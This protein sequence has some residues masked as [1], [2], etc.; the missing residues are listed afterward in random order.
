[1]RKQIVGAPTDPAKYDEPWINL[2]CIACVRLTSEDPAFPI[3]AAL[4][5]DGSGRGWKAAGAG[6]QS[7]WLEFD[8]PRHIER[9]HICFEA[10]ETRT[11]EFV[12]SC[13]LEGGVERELLRQ[14]FNFS[15]TT[16][17]EVEN[18]QVNLSAVTE[19]KVTITPDISGGDARASMR[20]LAVQ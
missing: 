13:T 11:Q 8:L 18:Y 4:S 7:I 2:E 10:E 1:M 12:L 19:L 9:I 15:P 16:P 14:Q 20:T 17:Q 5:N 3:E 6:E